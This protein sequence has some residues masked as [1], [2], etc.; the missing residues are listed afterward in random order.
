[1]NVNGKVISGVW[2]TNKFFK[3]YKTHSLYFMHSNGQGLVRFTGL[4][5]GSKERKLRSLALR[6]AR[7]K[8]L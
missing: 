6:Q 8:F 7:K 5:K 3:F 4:C 2:N 1:M